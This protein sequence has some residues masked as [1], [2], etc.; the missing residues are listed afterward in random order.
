MFTWSTHVLKWESQYF[1]NLNCSPGLRA[2]VQGRAGGVQVKADGR[3]QAAS[4]K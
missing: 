1:L 4:A 3:V 2:K